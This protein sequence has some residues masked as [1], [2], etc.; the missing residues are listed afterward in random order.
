MA[1]HDAVERILFNIDNLTDSEKQQL[2]LKLLDENHDNI[3]E[4]RG[5]AEIV[6]LFGDDFD[7]AEFMREQAAGDRVEGLSTGY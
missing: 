1:K 7:M 2:L 6:D 3:E 4:A 5:K